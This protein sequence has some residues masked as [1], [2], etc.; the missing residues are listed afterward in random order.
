MQNCVGYLPQKSF[1]TYGIVVLTLFGFFAVVVIGISASLTFDASFHCHEEAISK[2]KEP[3]LSK[4]VNTK[5]S[6]EYHE[7]F[8]TNLIFSLLI[9]NFGVVFV[10]S[11]IYGYLVKH[12]VEK[13]D[14]PTRPVTTNNENDQNGELVP[15]SEQNPRDVRKCLGDFSTFF[16]YIIHLIVAR[17]VPMLIFA[18]IFY[19]SQIP[20]HFSCPWTADFDMERAI[21]S[22]S[23][24]TLNSS[25]NLT[26]IGCTNPVGGKSK[27]LVHVVA[28]VDCVVVALTFVEL[29]YIAWLAIND[30]N[31]IT[32][33]AFCTVYLLRK[34]KR[35]RKVVNKF[36]GRFNP[37][38]LELFQMKDDFGEADISLRPLCD[39]Y[40]NVI[41]Q[42]GREHLNAYQK[43]FDRHGI[44]Q[45]R[46][47]ISEKVTKLTSPAEMFKPKKGNMPRRYPRTILVI[48]RPGIGKTMLTKK[49]LHQWKEKKMSFGLTK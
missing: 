28:I 7:K 19:L 27:K 46:L 23:N 10:L 47:K 13:F 31:F 5:C 16:I 33:Q 37:D 18:I 44:Y 40:V 9:F 11:I 15:N 4:D 43:K 25:H 17:I 20:D 3:S 14:Y 36:R 8:R 48:G 34:H 2:R 38:D 21:T 1:N 41:I 26:M 12:R 24:V 30:R 39:I 22:N 32:D 29:G 35:I 49:L 42:E 45:S 6:L